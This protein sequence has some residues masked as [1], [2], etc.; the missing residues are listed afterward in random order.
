LFLAVGSC[1]H[2]TV[3][4][5]TYS[6]LFGGTF[7]STRQTVFFSEPRREKQKTKI[8]HTEPGRYDGRQRLWLFLLPVGRPRPFCSRARVYRDEWAVHDDMTPEATR[9]AT[10]SRR[11][12]RAAQDER[13]TTRHATTSRHDKRTRRRHSMMGRQRRGERQDD[14][15][16]AQQD[17]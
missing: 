12:E 6:S 11:D 4:I 16:A 10:T 9:Q 14:E 3:R 17:R 5:E 15:N 1:Q 7:F 13:A 2:K 8:R